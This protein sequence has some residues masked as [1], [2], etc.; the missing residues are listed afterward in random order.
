[1][2]EFR[3]LSFNK[4]LGTIHFELTCDVK[5]FEKYLFFAIICHLKASTFSVSLLC[6]CITAFTLKDKLYVYQMTEFTISH[7]DYLNVLH[8]IFKHYFSYTFE[9]S[10]P[11]L[12]F[13]STS[14][15]IFPKPLPAFPQNHFGK[16]IGCIEV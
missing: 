6:E 2:D 11:V 8:K 14:Y 3:L 15:R 7:N 16:M 13:T 5:H 10:A 12:K 1:M 9:H 4:Q